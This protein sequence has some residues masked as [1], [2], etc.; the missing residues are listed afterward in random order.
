VPHGAAVHMFDI[1]TE[2]LLVNLGEHCISEYMLCVEC[3]SKQVPD[4]NLLTLAFV[5][6]VEILHNAQRCVSIEVKRNASASPED[7]VIAVE[8]KAKV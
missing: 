2:G 1:G 7:N 3:L 6:V 4:A 5:Y 8:R